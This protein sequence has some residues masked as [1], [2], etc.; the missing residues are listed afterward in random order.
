M[1]DAMGSSPL[2][3]FSLVPAIV[4][5]LAE[6]RIN[7]DALLQTVGIHESALAGEV[8]VPLA[9]V[10]SLFDASAA[11]L[12]DPLFGWNLASQIQ[13]GRYGLLEFLMRSA[14]TFRQGLNTLCKYGTMVNGLLTFSVQETDR[15]MM[16]C[17][18]VPGQRDALGRHLNEYTLHYLMRL[19]R[20]FG[21]GEDPISAV[22]LPH[23]AHEH[24]CELEA[25]CATSIR[26]GQSQGGVVLRATTLDLRSSIGDESLFNFLEQQIKAAAADYGEKDLLR[27]VYDVIMARLG[28][29]SIDMAAVARLLGLSERT[30]QRH[31]REVGSSYRDVLDLVRHDK[32]LR[33]LLQPQLTV[34]EIAGRLGFDSAAVFIRAFRRWTNLTPARWRLL[35]LGIIRAKERSQAGAD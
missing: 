18:A 6:R 22:Q 16:L 21:I 23:R 11:A 27:S 33:L 9:R 10:Q 20:S 17:F 1:I 34:A 3:R 4:A 25:A 12:G 35:E 28:R 26:F 31:L 24:A 29:S 14:G 8:Y 15:R 2:F 5:R 7:G 13:L 32:A 30:L 19:L